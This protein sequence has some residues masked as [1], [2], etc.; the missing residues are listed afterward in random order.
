MP[1]YELESE[2]ITA[3][4]KTT[5]AA[6]GLRER[7][8]L[9][10]LLRDCI[11]V[12]SPG[13]MVV[14]EEFGDWVESGRRIDLLGLDPDGMLVVVEL[15]RTEDGGHMEL[16]A[17][18][19]AAM[20]ST[21]SYE[22]AVE[23]HGRYLKAR[24]KESSDAAASILGHIESGDPAQF[25]SDVRIVLAAADFSKEITS[26][27]LWLN[28]QGPDVTC[29]R[30]RPYKLDGRTLLDV[31]QVI[32]LPE[33]TE[34]QIAIQQK[35]SERRAINQSY[36][37]FTRYRL[38]TATNSFPRL[39]KR[40]FIYEVVR[41]A[42]R[43]GTTPDQI[44]DCIP[45]RGASLFAV[46]DGELSAE[47]FSV[48]LPGDKSRR[49]FRRENELI[50]ANGKTYALTNQWGT[51]TEEAVAAVINSMKPGHGIEYEPIS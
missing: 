4:E 48:H 21:M 17:L 46:A 29:V 13:T 42:V 41:E 12:I 37:D 50:R 22:Q 33:A 51:Q 34:Y 20:V 3:L 47:E 38:T 39:A 14:T 36:R 44:K 6:E 2:K 26:T 49:Y 30:L 43:Q 35:S 8:D 19:Y 16:Q 18:R 45:W 23:A 11:D 31:Q 5:F 15:K 7:D 40:N 25:N 24:G 9:Q 28:G 1:L 32:P 10:R 27:V